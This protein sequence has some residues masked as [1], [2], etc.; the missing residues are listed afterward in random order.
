[1]SPGS[2]PIS[3]TTTSADEMARSLEYGP[4]RASHFA[5]LPVATKIAIQIATAYQR[6]P[7]KRATMVKNS[8]GQASLPSL[9]K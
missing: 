2:V 9:R 6:P 4:C 7:V 8:S 1:M 3:I 5:C